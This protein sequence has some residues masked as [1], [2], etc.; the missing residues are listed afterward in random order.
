MMVCAVE[1]FMNVFPGSPAF[2]EDDEGMVRL[3]TSCRSRSHE[4]QCQLFDLK[5]FKPRTEVF[6]MA[7]IK[8]LYSAFE[9]FRIPWITI[10]A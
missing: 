2:A 3:F 1:E 9:S 8:S 4:I 10:M 7:A 5:R 6:G